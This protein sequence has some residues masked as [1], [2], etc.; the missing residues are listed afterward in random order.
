M[1]PTQSTSYLPDR[2]VMG[3]RGALLSLMMATLPGLGWGADLFVGDRAS[4]FT[5][6][7]NLR[8][9]LRLSEQ[10]GQ[11]VFI[12]FWAE[13]CGSCK[14][15]LKD[16]EGIYNAHKNKGFQIWAI[17]LDEDPKEAAFG[18]REMG[19]S[20]P[21]LFDND[22]Q[23]AK[24]YEVNDIPSAVIVDRDGTIRYVSQDYNANVLSEYKNQ[25]EKLVN[26]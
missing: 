3:L 13:W 16:L 14:Q 22:H 21:V 2:V 19:I 11:I 1:T 4:N 18:A 7:S 26:E 9:N 17:S 15:Q 8:E 24:V 5:L 25:V 20:Y 12:T 6:K 10:R 23:I